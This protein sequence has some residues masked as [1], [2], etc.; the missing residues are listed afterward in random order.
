[1]STIAIFTLPV[2]VILVLVFLIILLRLVLVILFILILVL[3]VLELT[4]WVLDLSLRT[5][6]IRHG[7][8]WWILGPQIRMR[9]R[10]LKLV[11][12]DDC[13]ILVQFDRAGEW[14]G[15]RG[16]RKCASRGNVTL[17]MV[18]VLF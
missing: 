13:A 11:V 4:F 14:T 10:R 17:L 1:V 7:S 5:P 8:D 3:I 12:T 9:R 18:R 16:R 15:T 2:T 6:P